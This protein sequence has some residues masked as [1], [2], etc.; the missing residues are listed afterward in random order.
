MLKQDFLNDTIRRSV[1]SGLFARGKRFEAFLKWWEEM[2]RYEG[3][4]DEAPDSRHNL[5]LQILQ[6]IEPV[7]LWAPPLSYSGLATTGRADKDA[8]M[9]YLSPMLEFEPMPSVIHTICHEFCHIY[10]KHHR[11]IDVDGAKAAVEAG[12]GHGGTPHELEVES[13]CTK[14]GF[15]KAAKAEGNSYLATIVNAYVKGKGN[16]ARKMLSDTLQLKWE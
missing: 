14:L 1:D 5:R 12:L 3:E 8:A 9:I 7:I 6:E 13:L 4:E 2:V 10:L 11:H 15:P 16:R